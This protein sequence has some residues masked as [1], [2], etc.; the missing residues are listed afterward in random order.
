MGVLAGVPRIMGIAR[1]RVLTRVGLISSLIRRIMILWLIVR[2]I[3]EVLNGGHAHFN[4]VN[5]EIVFAV[6]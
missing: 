2:S 4:G 3:F 1:M 6:D 5:L